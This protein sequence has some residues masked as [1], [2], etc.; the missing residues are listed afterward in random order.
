MDIFFV[1][2]M[3]DMGRG[4]IFNNCHPILIFYEGGTQIRYAPTC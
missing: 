3:A 1:N 2:P 4:G